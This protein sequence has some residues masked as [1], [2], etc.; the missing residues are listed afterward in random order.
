MANCCSDNFNTDNCPATWNWDCQIVGFTYRQTVSFRNSDGSTPAPDVS[1][2]GFTMVVKNAAGTTVAT[3]T[4]GSGIAYGAN[5][6]EITVTV[7]SP[8]TATAGIYT[9]L[10]S[11]QR[12]STGENLPVFVGKIEVQPVP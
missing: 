8:I 12:A 6:N 11:W 5:D 7:G 1:G 10:L 3:L 9:Y 2:D 4:V